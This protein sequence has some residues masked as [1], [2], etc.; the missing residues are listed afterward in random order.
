MTFNLKKYRSCSEYKEILRILQKATSQQ[1]NLAWQSHTSSKNI[2]PIHHFE[3][4][5]VSREI[6]I[7]YDHQNFKLNSSLPLYVKLDYRT[8]VF[9][10]PEYRVKQNTIHFSFPLEIKT[11][12]LRFNPRVTF[13]PEVEKYISIRPAMS[14]VKREST[15]ELNVRVIDVSPVGL[16]LLISESNRLF[17]KSN[18]ILWITKLNEVEL[19]TPILAEVIYINSEFDPK[20]SKRKQ[21]DF[22]VGLK[23]SS[24]IQDEDYARFVN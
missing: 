7:S 8:S 3:I 4:D 6:V 24:P 13:T 15:S 1:D 12:E 21:K 10:I 2:V 5:F 19:A 16:G 11:E 20:Y 22:K 23:L 14:S 9:K 17:V 18:R